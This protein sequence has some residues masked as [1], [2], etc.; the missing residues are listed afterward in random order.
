MANAEVANAVVGADILTP[1]AQVILA[2]VFSAVAIFGAMYKY[3]SLQKSQDATKASSDE[4]EN[5]TN[6]AE[7]SFLKRLEGRLDMQQKVADDAMH[8]RNDLIQKVAR[9]EVQL[10]GMGKLQASNE[11]MQGRLNEKDETIKNLLQQAATDRAAFS[12]ERMKFLE[13][14]QGKDSEISKRDQRL[15]DMEQR[16]HQLEIRVAQDEVALKNIQC[17]L[18]KKAAAD[19][20]AEGHA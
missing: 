4:R 15:Y 3:L 10:E 5:K 1:G 13:I 20:I 11:S 2:I 17:P 9:M 16:Q 19:S 6:E 12:E 7:V 14:I 18:Q 8:E